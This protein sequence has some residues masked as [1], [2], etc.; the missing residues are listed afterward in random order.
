MAG[1]RQFPPVGG[2]SQEPEGRGR[3]SRIKCPRC[4]QTFPPK[5]AYCGSLLV[6]ASKRFACTCH[7]DARWLRCPWC[8]DTFDLELLDFSAQ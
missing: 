3:P 7:E 4:G 1:Q 6:L 5:C 2:L 8:R